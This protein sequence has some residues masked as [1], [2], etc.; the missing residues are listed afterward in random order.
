M[1][2]R[3]YFTTILKNLSILN[4]YAERECD[5]KTAF[6]HISTILVPL[7]DVSSL[8]FFLQV[9]VNYESGFLA[10]NTQNNCVFFFFPW[11]ESLD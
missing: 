5:T 7:P 10:N 9:K 4:E 8:S 11:T 3:K 6:G 1:C 2:S